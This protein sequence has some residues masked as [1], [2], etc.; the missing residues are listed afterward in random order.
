MTSSSLSSSS[1]SQYGIEYYLL[2]TSLVSIACF[3]VV[4]L[5]S[6]WSAKKCGAERTMRLIMKLI[7][8]LII[9]EISLLITMI[10]FKAMFGPPFQVH[11]ISDYG[12]GDS[13]IYGYGR[14]LL[15]LALIPSG[16]LCDMHTIFLYASLLGCIVEIV[17]DSISAVQ[18]SDYQMQIIQHGAP[19][20]RYTGMAYSIYIWRDCLSSGICL[21]LC[22]AYLYVLSMTGW[23]RG[24]RS[25][26]Y[27]QIEGGLLDRSAIMRKHL[28]L[29]KTFYTFKH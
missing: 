28:V 19:I 23:F 5:L 15:S 1:N 2:F 20:G 16:L 25:L 21:F 14:P 13:W 12:N 6:L 24:R 18:V 8:L 9:I 4:Y 17:F 7:R 11:I 27:R 26:H 3:A 22:L 29:R 10:L